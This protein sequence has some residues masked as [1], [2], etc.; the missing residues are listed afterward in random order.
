VSIDPQDNV[1]AITQDV[2]STTR[3]Q[4][5]IDEYRLY[6]DRRETLSQDEM[7][8]LMRKDISI[9]LEKSGSREHII[10]F[11]VGYQ[12]TD[13]VVVNRVAARLA[14]LFVDENARIRTTQAD[15]ADQFMNV[16]LH[17]ANNA[18]INIEAKIAEYKQAHNGSLPEQEQ[19]LGATLARLQSQHQA[20]QDALN[21]TQQHRLTLEGTI[22]LLQTQRA[23]RLV[24]QDAQSSPADTQIEAQIREL[25][26]QLAVVNKEMER[27]SAESEL[28]LKE[29]ADY[30]ARIEQLPLRE[31]EMAPLNRE[32]EMA[33]ATY[34]SLLEKKAAAGMASAMEKQPGGQGL[35]VL[36][37]PR[38]PKVP[39]G[40]PRSIFQTMGCL[41]SFFVGMALAVGI[42]I[43][44]DRFL[45][46]WELSPEINIL[47]R[48][49]ALSGSR[50]LENNTFPF[51]LFRPEGPWTLN[52]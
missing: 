28:V 32:Y 11:R 19:S 50:H 42:D 46:E 38:I 27:R 6:R 1:A 35:M 30:Q 23:E 13:P 2:L 26:A 37:P 40:P 41:L 18:L 8:Q 3:L 7:I 52:Q 12:G 5:V 45:G 48:I 4:Q 20:I 36:D 31:L 39:I 51:R 43:L 29:A 25:R 16:Q 47:G 24:T 21:R 22:D 44:K 15:E 34:K 10:A 17:E 9:K 49:P 33:K 14:V